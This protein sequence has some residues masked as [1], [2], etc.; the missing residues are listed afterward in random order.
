MVQDL[1]AQK[2]AAIEAALLPAP[3]IKRFVGEDISKTLAK[4][5]LMDEGLA[6]LPQNNLNEQVHKTIY[7]LGRIARYLAKILDFESAL[8]QSSVDDPFCHVIYRAV[9]G[10]AHPD[11]ARA[12][13]VEAI[14]VASVDHGVTPP[15]A[16]A[17][18][19]AATVRS[20]YEMS[21]ASG[22]GA[23][24]DV[25]GGA[26]AK[27]AEFFQ[28][29][30]SLS[31][32]KGLS[33]DTAARHV[34][35]DYLENKKRLQGLGHRV[36]SQDPRRDV[37]WKLA[38]SSNLAGPCVALSEIITDIFSDL[39]GKNLPIN[40]DGVIGAV[41]ADMGLNIDL[42]K[43]LFIYGR[44]A[45]LSAHYFEEITTQRQMRRVDFSK[46][47]YGGKELRPYLPR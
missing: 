30:A 6:S 40:V 36:H 11:E 41:I 7:C 5:M 23:I 44:A 33:L 20:A 13:L 8:E 29:C 34:L 26:G 46:A 18:I 45:G 12:K 21:L 27:A 10:E 24:T 1:Q 28:R 38:K 14:I 37:L 22:V 32:E 4:A 9:S 25:H 2:T 35:Q 15:S 47:R 17:G 42:A 43:A 39:K 31:E 3:S 16:Q 19:I